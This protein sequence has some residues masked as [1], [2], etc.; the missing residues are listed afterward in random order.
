MQIGNLNVKDGVLL[1]PLA[2]VSS[3]P[4]R[5]LAVKAG[6]SVTYTEMVSSEG[7]VRNQNKTFDMMRFKADEQPLGIQLFGA[8][9]E[10]M[11]QAADVTAKKFK[12]DIIDINFGCPVKKVVNKNGGS[13]VLKDLKLTEDIIRAT[14]EGAGETPVTIKIRTGWDDAH[15]VFLE[16]GQIAQRAGAKAV[17]LH[18]RSRAK[19][20]S[21]SADWSSI[22][23][24]KRS[25]DIPVIGNGDAVTPQDVKRMLDE[26][27]CDAVMIGRAALGNPFIFKQMRHYLATG[28]LLEEPSVEDKIEMAR[29][30]AQLMQEQFG[31]ERGA[32]MMRRYLGWYVKGFKGA[33]ELRPQLFQVTTISDI[34][35]VFAEYLAKVTD[36]P[37]DKERKIA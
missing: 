27:G 6:A 2:G 24:L 11:R 22:R 35:R 5:V 25:V 21:G 17:S 3:R 20:F 12:P 1:A 7:I 19:G 23:E 18:A 4:F 30:H 14:V 10:V 36:D 29:L 31:E 26:T 15:P 8:N 33:S 9:P 37:S 34:D 32:I 16:V 13:A 28:E